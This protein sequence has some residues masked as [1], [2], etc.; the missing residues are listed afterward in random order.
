[1]SLLDTFIA[2]IRAKIGLVVGV[3]VVAVV[4]AAGAYILM[5]RGEISSLNKKVGELN[6]TIIVLKQNSE[7]LKGNIKTLQNVN[8]TNSETISKMLEERKKSDAAIASLAKK[9]L[10][11]AK[12][13]KDLN[14][15]IDT[16]TKDPTK[17]GALAPV[18][19][20]TLKA[21]HERKA[22]AQ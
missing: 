21:I 16:L 1:M 19:V 15:Y 18:L 17:D 14:A 6:G 22:G 7:T 5:L 4:L 11:N 3:A 13:I 20:E 9:D 8:N 2:P 12:K 10:A